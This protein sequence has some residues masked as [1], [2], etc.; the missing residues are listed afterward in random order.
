MRARSQVWIYAGLFALAGLFA[1]L[2]LQAQDGRAARLRCANNLRQLGIAIVQYGDDKRFL[3]HVGKTRDLDGGFE[4]SDT[5][6]QVRALI[7]YGY[8]DNPEG[9]VCPESDDYRLPV[10]DNE[11][12]ENM[13]LWA[14]EG[15][16]GDSTRSPWVTGEDPALGSL[17]E[18]S[19]ATTRRGY[20]R[21]VSSVRALAAD[22]AM[23]D[24]QARGRGEVAG[25]HDEGWNLL[26]ADATVAFVAQTDEQAQLLSST[27]AG[28]GFL[29][30][31]D[32][33]DASGIKPLGPEPQ[34]PSAWSADYRGEDGATLRLE[35]RSYDRRSQTWGLQGVLTGADGKQAEVY[36]RTTGE[37]E[38]QGVAL[39]G[40][41]RV[42]LSAKAGAATG[43]GTGEGAEVALEV[44][45]RRQRFKRTPRPAQ[46]ASAEVDGM[47]RELVALGFLGALRSG[48]L[49]A[50]RAFL[51]PAGLK[52]LE[53]KTSLEAMAREF[54]DASK[55]TLISMV[56]K[57]AALVV[58]E[59]DG[60]A[61]ID[62]GGTP[63]PADG[64]GAP[65]PGPRRPKPPATPEQSAVGALKSIANAQ[66]L[67]READKDQNGELDYAADLKA[68]GATRLISPE[69]ATGSLSGYRFEVCRGSDAPQFVWMA[70]ASPDPAGPGGRYLAT[71]HAGVIFVSDTP[72]VLDTK[73]CEIKGG[74]PLGR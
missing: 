21:N 6:R 63:S 2:V 69:L 66:T 35:G 4:S 36:A 42:D 67:F 55:Q 68:L 46:P 74:K 62:F 25:N 17:R 9:L 26:Q 40:Q 13:R 24:G 20:N 23:R 33:R 45:G 11:V 29:A 50:A 38:L 14:W 58:Q 19:Y 65:V 61:R 7:W 5:P 31:R 73:T 15:A 39:Y 57:L 56:P 43:E 1:P 60:V 3:P 49:P 41:R 8:H 47:T 27:E 72:F 71:N 64:R 59:A 16:R 34:A 48:N 18:L 44:E 53:A 52:R 30:V 51:T 70:T 32:Q 54:K 37:G 28:G 22:R 10:T 12:L